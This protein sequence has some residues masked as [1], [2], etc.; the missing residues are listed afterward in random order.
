MK[1]NII[2]STIFMAGAAIG[3]SAVGS[4]MLL[5]RVNAGEKLN[6]VVKSLFTHNINNKDDNA[7]NNSNDTMT[8]INKK[9]DNELSAILLPK[10]N[11]NIAPLELR[12]IFE[13]KGYVVINKN[14]A[15]INNEINNFITNMQNLKTTSLDGCVDPLN[16]ACTFKYKHS[17]FLMLRKYSN[18][19]NIH[20]YSP[21]CNGD[22]EIIMNDEIKELIDIFEH[23]Y[24]DLIMNIVSYIDYI[25]DPHREKQ[26]VVD[27]K[28]ISNLTSVKDDW[29][30]DMFTEYKTSEKN[31]YDYSAL[32]LLNTHNISEHIIS[33][34]QKINNSVKNIFDL[35]IPSESSDIGYLIDQT[36]EICYHYPEFT[37]LTDDATYNVLKIQI[38]K[39]EE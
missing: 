20:Y 10:N 11:L 25:I 19:E 22:Y 18:K 38:K 26:Y 6:G 5:K 13:H 8:E 12:N 37:Y 28:I 14:L 1:I 4:Y 35:N 27:L 39:I 17:R 2:D 30:Q 32:F 31:I 16:C 23:K 34:G 33:I 7:N 24:L 36:K 29:H 9:E 3:A 21:T 15:K